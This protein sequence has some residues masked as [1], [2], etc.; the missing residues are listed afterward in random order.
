MDGITLF[1]SPHFTHPLTHSPTHHSHSH[2]HTLTYSHTHTTH[3]PTNSDDSI[4]L[5]CKV[6]IRR[7]MSWSST[8]PAR[9]MFPMAPWSFSPIPIRCVRGERGKKGERG[10]RERRRG[11]ARGLIS[12]VLQSNPW[13]SYASGYVD[14]A[15]KFSNT[16]GRYEVYAKLPGGKGLYPSRSF[17]FFH[18]NFDESQNINC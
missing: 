2:T 14:T 1:S 6:G 4:R 3:S 16:F 11:G 17:L 13:F 12:R 15:G 9:S 5:D 18:I 7:T 10:K 8:R